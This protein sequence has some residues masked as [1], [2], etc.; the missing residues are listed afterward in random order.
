M[1]PDNNTVLK[2]KNTSPVKDTIHNSEEKAVST[3]DVSNNLV[4]ARKKPKPHTNESFNPI[5]NLGK[6]KI[7]TGTYYF[8]K[9]DT[10][11]LSN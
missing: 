3:N 1:R 8:K 2:P 4:S 5:D 11:Y 7:S 6:K 9:R 10:Y